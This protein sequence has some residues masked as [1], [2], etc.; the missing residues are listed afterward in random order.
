M[1][2]YGGGFV[3]ECVFLFLFFNISDDDFLGVFLSFYCCVFY[4]VVMN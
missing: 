3:G 2:V 4:F 1:F